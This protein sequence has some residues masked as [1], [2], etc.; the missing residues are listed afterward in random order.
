MTDTKYD[1]E[2]VKRL[3]NL[4]EDKKTEDR[5]VEIDLDGDWYYG[6]AEITEVSWWFDRL[7]VVYETEDAIDGWDQLTFSAEAGDDGTI[8][9]TGTAVGVV[10]PEEARNLDTPGANSAEKIYD[11][12]EHL[13]IELRVAA[14]A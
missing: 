13:G 4:P 14:Q 12:L 5:G 10:P 9:V 3:Q 2:K 7:H 6:D 8:I 11:L 1:R